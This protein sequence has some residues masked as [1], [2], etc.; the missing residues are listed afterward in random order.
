MS[1]KQAK[2][3]RRIERERQNI[4]AIK[5]EKRIA[6]LENAQLPPPTT[7]WHLFKLWL[8]H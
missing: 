5:I 3:L 6:K 7:F 8:Q 2:R 4:I 1:Q